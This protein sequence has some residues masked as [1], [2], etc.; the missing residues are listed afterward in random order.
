M[1][2]EPVTKLDKKN[3]K[4]TK[5]KKKKKKRKDKDI[6]SVSYEIIIIIFLIYGQFGTTWKLDFRCIWSLIST[7]SSIATFYLTKT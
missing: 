3:I 5:K 4:T 1:K 2:L 6:I 7:R